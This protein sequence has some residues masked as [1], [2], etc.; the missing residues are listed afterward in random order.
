MPSE[1]AHA[2]PPSTSNVSS[3]AY[4]AAQSPPTVSSAALLVTNPDDAATRWKKPAAADEDSDAVISSTTDEQLLYSTTTTL[5]AINNQHTLTSVITSLVHTTPE[6]IREAILCNLPRLVGGSQSNHTPSD[7]PP[8]TTASFSFASL[9]TLDR[10][11]SGRPLK[12]HVPFKIR[13]DT[14]G[15]NM[16]TF[17]TLPA[18]IHLAFIDGTITLTPQTADTTLVTLTSSIAVVPETKRG[19][20]AGHGVFTSINSLSTVNNIVNNE[21]SPVESSNSGIYSSGSFGAAIKTMR[22]GINTKNFTS[23]LGGSSFHTSTPSKTTG[24]AILDHFTN[25]VLSLHTQYA[26]Y[27]QVD[28]AMYK[29]FEEETVPN[30][31]RIQPHEDN[32]INRS[33]L[34][35]DDSRTEA[36]F[37]R[38]KVRQRDAH[39]EP[40]VGRDEANTRCEHIGANT[41]KHV[42]RPP[43]FHSTHTHVLARSKHSEPA[44]QRDEADTLPTDCE[45]TRSHCSRTDRPHTHSRACSR[46]ASILNRPFS[47]TNANTMRP[48]DL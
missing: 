24:A 31:P 12:Q 9:I 30:A 18:L 34:F 14:E 17:V 21:R 15:D 41:F 43:Q 45:V 35:G 19:K 28:A 8:T 11:S 37:K 7:P 23:S 13:V 32:M 44:I 48:T 27:E 46:E 25:A 29:Q 47:A 42:E 16:L 22:S 20:S 1:K 26:R 33:L 6:T 5:H 10:S 36:K 2:L 40:A 38:I 39:S 3:S 4:I